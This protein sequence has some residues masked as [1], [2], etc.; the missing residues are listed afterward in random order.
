MPVSVVTSSATSKK[1]PAGCVVEFSGSLIEA[2]LI[3]AVT[4]AAEAELVQVCP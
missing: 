3:A 1:P 4:P 2:V